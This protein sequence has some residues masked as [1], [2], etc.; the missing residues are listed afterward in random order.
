VH[1]GT[2][3]PQFPLPSSNEPDAGWSAGTTGANRWY[4]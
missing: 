1:R 3:W 4:L 2:E